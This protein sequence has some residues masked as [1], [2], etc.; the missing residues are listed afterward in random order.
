[1]LLKLAPT[2]D[3]HQALLDTM[4]QF[5]AASNYVA[6]IAFSQK[7]ANKFALQKLVYGELRTTYK[8]AAQLAIRAISKASEA[9]KRD[10]SI[11]PTFKP[12]G[13]IVYDQ[14]VMSFKGLLSVSLLTLQGRVLVPFRV[15]GYQES[16]LDQIKGQ[17]DLIYRHG[18]FFLAVTLEVPTPTP[19]APTDT[20]GVDLG[21][22]N[23]ATDSEGE[24]FSGEGVERNRKRHAALR[25]RLQKR[26]TKSAKR[27]LKKLSGKEARF[28]KNTN[29]V[30]AKR[31]VHKAKTNQQA[32][33]LEELRHIRQRTERTVRRSQRA[34]H[35]SWSFGQLRSFLS[36]KAALA[37][38]PLHF[39]DPAYTSRTCSVCGHCDKANRQ[40]QA[41][42]VCQSCGHS[43]HAD[44]NAAK[45]ISRASV[46]VPIAAGRA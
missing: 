2:K 3:Q 30:I 24:T 14:R 36:Y 29:H 16:R 31:I 33:A 28:R 21:I 10:K 23:L 37:G 7:T 35:S 27:H 1:M 5:N 19:N 4:H 32:L 26:G 8:L 25:G 9:Y 44:R 17:A 41:L 6:E 38:V 11:Q 45:N 15:G 42:F 18:I 22:V 20:L 46:M 12:E 34:K 40:S 13:A 39:V 43:D